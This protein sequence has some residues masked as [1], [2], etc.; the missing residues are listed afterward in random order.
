MSAPLPPMSNQPS[1]D[2]GSS[3]PDLREAVHQIHQLV[4][5]L[6]SASALSVSEVWAACEAL[7][8]AAILL[9]SQRIDIQPAAARHLIQEALRFGRSAVAAATCA[10]YTPPRQESASDT[11]SGLTAHR[12]R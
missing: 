2:G 10:A 7:N 5:N 3:K 11:R 12:S 6:R 1:N 4:R 8:C 9:Q